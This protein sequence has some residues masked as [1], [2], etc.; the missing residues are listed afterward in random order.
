M[1]AGKNALEALAHSAGVFAVAALVYAVAVAIPLSTANEPVV[2][3]LSA[4][5]G[6]VFVFLAVRVARPAPLDGWVRRTG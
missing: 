2:A 3:G 5:T 1:R 6:V 4:Y